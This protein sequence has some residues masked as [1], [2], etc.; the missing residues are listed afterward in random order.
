MS[1]TRLVATI[2]VVVT[3]TVGVVRRMRRRHRSVGEGRSAEVVVLS[4]H[5]RDRMYEFDRSGTG[6]TS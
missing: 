3:V 2:A 4:H 1:T 6:S 5:R